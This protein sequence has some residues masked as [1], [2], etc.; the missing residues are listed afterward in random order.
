MAAICAPKPWYLGKVET[1]NTFKSRQ[2]NQ[3]YILGLNNKFAPF[4]LDG[5]KWEKKIA[6]NQTRGF[7]DNAGHNADPPTGPSAAQKVLHLELMLNQIANYCPVISRDTIVKRSTSIKDVWQNTKLHY[8]FH[9]T[10]TT[11]ARFL[12]FDIIHL[13]TD[14]RPED[15]YQRLRSFIDDNLLKQTVSPTTAKLLLLMT[16]PPL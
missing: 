15:I 2:E 1:I 4:L 12:D 14:E 16:C 6:T 10:A 7:T 8:C 13:E 9:T 3:V 5:S 11:G